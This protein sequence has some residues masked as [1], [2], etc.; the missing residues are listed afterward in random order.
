MVSVALGAGV[1]VAVLA[2]LWGIAPLGTALAL[3][4]VISWFALPGLVLAW[5]LY[6]RQDG[7]WLAALLSGPAWGYILSSLALLGFWMAGLRGGGWIAA[8]PVLASIVVWLGARRLAPDVRPPAFSRRDVAAIAFVLLAIPAIAGRPYARVGA[9]LPEG[10]AY[11]AYF[12]ADFVW[13]MTVASEVSKGA[14]PPQNPFQVKDALHYYWLMY[15]LPGAEYRVGDGRVRL[16]DILLVNAFWVGLVF[17]AFL[18]F[19]VRHVVARPWP[20]ALAVAFV[21]FCSSFEGADR[22]WLLWEQGA[23]L[24]AV[25]VINIDAVA[26]W[27]YQGMKVDGLHRAVLYQPQHQLGYI[28]GLSALLLIVQAKDA[29]R[30]RLLFV[31][32]VLLAGSMLLSTVSALMLTV[33]AA[34]YEFLRLVQARRWGAVIPCALA[35]AVPMAGALGVIAWFEYVDSASA[36]DPIVRLGANQLAMHRIAWSGFLNFGPVLLLAS[37]GLAV[38]IVRGLWARMVPLFVLFAT[39]VV[40]YFWVDIPE[41]DSVYVAW[42]ASHL[43]FIGCAALIGVAFQE[44]GGLGP[45]GR[46]VSAAGVA[47]VALVAVPTVLIDIYNAQDVTNRAMGPGFRWTVILTPQELEAFDWL[48]RNTLADA[49][50]QI[51]PHV[52]ERDAYYL[53]AFAE[54]RMAGGLPTGLIPLAK[55]RAV[56]EQIREVYKATDAGDAAQRAQ[57]LCVDYLLIGAPER[58][59]YPAFQ[60]I[61]DAA[62]HLFQPAF[63]NDALAV[64]AVGSASANCR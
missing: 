22:L 27:Y 16:D 43:A 19:L 17:A 54:R 52:R 61:V 50:V 20:A 38:S 63:R 42:R 10:R 5:R 37:V 28:L 62:P 36:G 26:N 31:A 21:L 23:P 64:Y 53:T 13:E 34:V 1:C 14:V 60:P 8:A 40:F 6:G 56:S 9:D 7:G 15:L 11:R 59:A 32:G 35:A 29:A 44:W 18:Y 41:H 3:F 4:G 58:S 30:P 2:S 39:C 51:E 25:R 33:I 47:A 46:T 55:Y 24:D 57:R 45:I 49:R 12:T 48:K